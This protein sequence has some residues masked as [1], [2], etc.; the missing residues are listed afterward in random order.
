MAA[1][2]S[3]N[4]ALFWLE[5][6]RQLVTWVPWSARYDADRSDIGDWALED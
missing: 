4:M 5:V 1:A 6:R 2:A 3:G